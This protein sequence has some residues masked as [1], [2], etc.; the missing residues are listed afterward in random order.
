MDIPRSVDAPNRRIRTVILGGIGLAGVAALTLGLSRLEPAAPSVDRGTVWVDTVKRGDMI[1]QVRGLGTLVPTDLHWI[2]ATSLGRVE[3]ILVRPGAV[4]GA[5][6]VLLELSNPEL[7]QSALETQLQL[8]AARAEYA[9]LRVQLSS[10]LLTQKATAATANSDARQAK[11]QAAANEELAKQGLIGRLTYQLSAVKAEETATRTHLEQQRLAIA[12]QA[13]DA[14]LAVQTAKIDQLQA[15]LR[16]RQS[17]VSALKVKAG[18]PGVLQQLPLDLGQQVTPGT[19]LAR[20][21]DPRHLKASLRIAETQAKDIQLGQPTSIDTRN[22]IVSGRVSRIDPSVQNGTVTVDV[23]LDGA[24][25]KGARPDLS[26]DGTIELERL[27]NVLTIGRPAFGQENGTV[28]LFKLRAD[29]QQAV[30]VLVKLGR[31]S[32]NTIEVL[33]GLSVG[34]R[35]ILSDTAA[36]ENVER[37]RLQ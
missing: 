4:V 21:A 11:L 29:G 25:P 13:T 22:G 5:N 7:Q 19:N 34:D 36:Q 23:Q 2:A 31:S 6:T 15:L 37:I 24:L 20:V 33:S 3:R 32:V 18:T 28:K 8:Q 27:K 1:R 14:Q 9:N 17:L 12:S 35:A 26:V 16:L 30:R 10:Q